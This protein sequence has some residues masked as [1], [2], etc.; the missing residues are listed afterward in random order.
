MPKTKT[1]DDQREF[2]NESLRGSS[3][4]KEIL[5][6]VRV[7]ISKVKNALGSDTESETERIRKL[8]ENPA[9]SIAEYFSGIPP[10][11]LVGLPEAIKGIPKDKLDKDMKDILA[12]AQLAL[13]MHDL[14]DE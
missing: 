9:G 3:L 8:N 14:E 2:A 5:H 4:D 7:V 6:M 13:E 11:L 12:G 1:K 10:E